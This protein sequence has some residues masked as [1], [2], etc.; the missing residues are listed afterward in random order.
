MRSHI[1]VVS[2]LSGSTRRDRNVSLRLNASCSAATRFVV[3]NPSIFK[4]A[5]AACDDKSIPVMWDEKT[6]RKKA[7][8]RLWE[9]GSIY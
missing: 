3:L 9:A 1:C 5:R 6:A 4:K 7:K 8:K 2:G